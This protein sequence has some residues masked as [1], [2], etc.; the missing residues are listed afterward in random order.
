MVEPK[1]IKA[2]DGNCGMY[3]LAMAINS[4][5]TYGVSIQA[6]DIVDIAISNGLSIS[7][8]IY[9]TSSLKSIVELIEDRYN[10]NLSLEVKT[11]NSEEDL[12]EIL[13]EKTK[14]SYVLFPYYA[15]QG[16]PIVSSS[17]KMDRGHWAVIYDICGDLLLA[18]Q[19]NS[20]AEKLRVLR[21]ISL[22]KM[23]NSNDQLN[24]VKVNM[25]KY[26]KCKIQ[27]NNKELAYKVRCNA[28]LCEI[29][30]NVNSKGCMYKTDLANKAFILKI[31]Q[32]GRE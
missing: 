6:E 32:G 1:F 12:R 9:N 22:T 7:G 2:T 17:P 24:Y 18:K 5:D 29:N 20:K 15:F 4:Y 16:M 30:S 28:E 27:V 10:I 26:N 3:C 8:E 21:G 31:G 19:S 14:D 13:I 23:F 25:G 11:F